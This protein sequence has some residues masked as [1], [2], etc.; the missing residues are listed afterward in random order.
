MGRRVFTANTIC[1]GSSTDRHTISQSA[2]SDNLSYLCGPQAAFRM[3][4]SAAPI[5]WHCN[6]FARAAGHRLPYR[7]MSAL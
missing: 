5:L 1:I 7:V 3:L 4:Q 2:H 6:D